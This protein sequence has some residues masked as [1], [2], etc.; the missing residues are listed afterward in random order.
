M[1]REG[2]GK[3]S[4]RKGAQPN[5]NTPAVRRVQYEE[6]DDEA[7]VT[8][9]ITC[10]TLNSDGEEEEISEGEQY[11]GKVKQAIELA[12][13][14]SHSLRLKGLLDLRKT[15]QTRAAEMGEL[16]NLYVTICDLAEK[17]VKRGTSVGERVAGARLAG[18][19]MLVSMNLAP[20]ISDEVYM[21]LQPTMLVVCQDPTVSAVVRE[22]VCRAVAVLGYFGAVEYTH[23][24]DSIN[25]L[26]T[27]FSKALPKGNGEL[28]TLQAAALLMH[29]ASLQ[30]FH[31]LL[32]LANRA[33][34]V[35]RA[36]TL[37]AEMISVLETREL[38]M[39][40]EVGTGC[41]LIYELVRD[42]P[43]FRWRRENE[44]LD[45][46]ND[47]ATD[48]HKHRGKKERKQQRAVFRSVV[49]S[50]EDGIFAPETVTLG[51]KRGARDVLEIDSWGLK[52]RYDCVC[53]ALEQGVNAHLIYNDGVRASFGLAELDLNPEAESR[54]QRQNKRRY[55]G[56]MHKQRNL[57]RS[58]NRDNRAIAATYED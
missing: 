6:E 54:E 58:K 1:P 18:V 26:H 57:Q 5:T 31:L 33:D 3:R 12:Q 16:E 19:I 23:L 40:T 32:T 20:G 27:V 10:S 28:P 35:T 15:L 55:A 49:T 45:M 8:S 36:P 44:M 52:Y 46:L 14:K 29:S 13:E 56:L 9:D 43:D 41:A 11:E 25:T 7:S 53:R 2:K 21:L 4:G 48:S 39:R 30:G 50:I 24:Q 38:E 17:S 34:V 51:S 42:S 47:L 22:E 37:L